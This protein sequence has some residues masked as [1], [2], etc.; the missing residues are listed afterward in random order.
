VISGAA[1]TASYPGLEVAPRL[2]PRVAVVVSHPI[3]H[4]CPL[5][6]SL[7]RDARVRLHVMFAS[8]A[9]AVEFFDTDF[10]RRV[11]WQ[12]DLLAGFDHQFL[13]GAS[14]E[15]PGGRSVDNSGVAAALEAFAPDAVVIYG[16]W[17]RISLRALHWARRGG[18]AVLLITD[19]ELRQRRSALN[20]CRKAILLPRL[21]RRIDAFLTVG[22]CNEAYYARYGAD[23]NRFFR[24]PFPIDEERI[25]AALKRRSKL[26]S[27]V[28]T[29]LGMPEDAL[30]ALAM[31]KLIDRKGHHDLI[32]ASGLLARHDGRSVHLVLAGD[33]PLRRRLEDVA[34]R[35][36]PGLVHFAGFVPVGN[37]PD[38]LVAA[39]MFVHPSSQDP[40]PLAITEA[41][42]AGLPVIASDR[43]GS[44]G[45]TDD[46]RVGRN[47]IEFRY[48][49]VT[50]LAAAL[51]TLARDESL[52]R[53]MGVA[54][55]D[56]FRERSM[57]ISVD[58]FV[59]A[60]D[61]VTNVNASMR[62]GA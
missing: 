27:D 62:A 50:G 37:V 52:R 31:G 10:S 21:M 46:A 41:I 47:A 32:R 60:V 3:Q 40:H 5:Y 35:E 15:P 11:R 45:P 59:R 58:G 48:G 56:V 20:R 38:Y 8:R 6:R 2:P 17:H 7:T 57:S 29:S 43:I 26:R 42:A 44:V 19:G 12:E 55:L 18:K 23:V 4:F 30:V 28:R 34:A 22:D 33:G 53:T 54:S 14:A 25:Q 51:Q 13:P 16:F 39:D 49:D 1:A 61:A 24:S 36:A 9:G